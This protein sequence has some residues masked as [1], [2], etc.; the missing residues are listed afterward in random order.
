M[1]QLDEFAEDLSPYLNND[2]I[3]SIYN[4]G[5]KSIAK[6]EKFINTHGNKC[7]FAK[8]SS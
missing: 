2:E 3:V 7:K 6:I 5:L 4:M 8:R 1:L